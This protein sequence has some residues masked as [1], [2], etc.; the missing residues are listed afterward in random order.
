MKNQ[1]KRLRIGL[2]PTR[3]EAFANETTTRQKERIMERFQTLAEKLD[4]DMIGIEEINEEG[5]LMTY[6]DARAAYEKL[7]AAGVDALIFPHCNFGQEE[8]V[9]RLAKDMGVPVLIWGPRDGAPNGLEWRPTDSQCGMFAT[10]KL[11]M[12]Y[13]VTFSY[14]ENCALESDILDRELADFLAVVS[15]VKAFRAMRI[16]RISSRPKEFLS[17]VINEAELLER[18]DIEIVPGEPTVITDKVDRILAEDKARMDQLLDSFTDAGL[19]ISALG[20]GR[21]PLAAIELAL[22]D[23]A[24]EN[25]CNAISCEC[26]NLFRKK[27]GVAPCFILGDLNDRGI[28][29]ACENDVHA[30]ITSVMAVAASRYTFPS[31]VADLTIRH[32]EKDNVELLWHCGS[33]AKRLKKKGVDGY[34]VKEGKGFYEL[35]GGDITVLRF[36]G[37]G[38]K[39]YLF[40]GEAKGTEGPVTNGNYLW[41]ETKD[42]VKW[43]KKFIFGPYIHHVVGIHGRYV[44]IFKEACRYLGIM[45]DTPDMPNEY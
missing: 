14:I 44:T 6:R 1:E 28:P 18:F 15:V 13:G 35:E 34:I 24:Q 11:L 20:E 17:V 29:A 40:A 9:G 5:M 25:C 39:Y 23:F 12:H 10:T 19:D 8:A 32:P 2:V 36:D 4:F 31:F 38:G 22:I 43:E 30:A 26:W 21:Y 33:F 3:R 42:W 37:I 27:Y 7:S 16:A 45:V 41:I